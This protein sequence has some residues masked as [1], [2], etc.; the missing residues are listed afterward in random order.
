MVPGAKDRRHVRRPVRV[1]VRVSDNADPTHGE[2]VFDALDLSQGGAFLESELLL[3]V[4]DELEITFAIPGEL[5]RIR[6]HAKVAWATRS[7]GAKRKPGMGLQFTDLKQ[8]DCQLIAD[9]VRSVR[10]A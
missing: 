1:S 2:I 4:G 7:S 6:A 10:E 8:S 9:F 3:E 5:R